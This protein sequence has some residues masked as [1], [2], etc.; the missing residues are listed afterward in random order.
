MSGGWIGSACGEVVLRPGDPV[1]VGGSARPVG[2]LCGV[3]G[4]GKRVNGRHAG[5]AVDNRSRKG[6]GVSKGVDL[7]IL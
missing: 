1:R 2:I 7:V 5:I 3:H 6:V 4:F